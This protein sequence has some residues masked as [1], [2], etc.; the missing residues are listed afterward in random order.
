MGR[1]RSPRRPSL[2]RLLASSSSLQCLQCHQWRHEGSS[3]PPRRERPLVRDT[4]RRRPSADDAVRASTPHPLSWPTA[5]VAPRHTEWTIPTMAVQMTRGS[6]RWWC[7]LPAHAS[8]RL[9]CRRSSLSGRRARPAT[10]SNFR[11]SSLVN[12]WPLVQAG[13][14]CRRT[15]AAAGPL[16]LRLRLPPRTT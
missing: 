6:A 14:G 7:G 5:E 11:A 16:G 10:S 2:P 13:S 8:I 15:A 9:R 12:C 3:P 4:A 1:G